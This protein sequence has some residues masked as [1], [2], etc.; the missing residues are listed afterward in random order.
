M[1][2]LVET[3]IT[4]GRIAVTSRGDTSLKFMSRLHRGTTADDVMTGRNR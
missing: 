3:S 4:S 1:D 2:A